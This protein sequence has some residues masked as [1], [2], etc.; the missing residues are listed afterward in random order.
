MHRMVL[1]V[2]TGACLLL[3]FM[4]MLL[5]P[6]SSKD[7]L[8]AVTLGSPF[9]SPNISLNSGLVGYWTMDGKN[10][11]GVGALTSATGGSITTS[12]SDKIHTFTTSG[13][14]TPNG[15]GTVQYLVVAGGGGGGPQAAV[16]AGGGGAG[17]VLTGTT[18]VTAQA[19][20]ITV[21]NGGTPG[22]NGQ[23]SSLGSVVTAIGGGYGGSSGSPGNT[24]G[25][26]GGG[27]DYPSA[28]NSGGAG[29]AGQGNRGGNATTYSGLGGG[30]AGGGGAGGAGVDM[31]PQSLNGT[32][33]GV[34]IASSISGASVYYGGGGGGGSYTNG[35]PGNGGL[36]GGGNGSNSASPGADGTANTGGGGGGNGGSGGSGIVIIRFTPSSTSVV[37]NSGNANSISLTQATAAAGKDGQALSFNG[38]AAYATAVDAASLKPTAAISYGGW[39]YVPSAPAS[40]QS[41]LEKGT[42]TSTAGYGLYVTS[43]KKFCL[44][45]K[46]AGGYEQGAGSVVTVG[47]WHH[48]MVTYDSTTPKLYV[49]GNLQTL[50]SGTGCTLTQNTGAITQDTSALYLGARSSP[51]QFFSGRLDD[52]RV[53]N[54]ALKAAEVSLLS[55]AG[56]G[57]TIAK[58]SIAPSTGGSTS[59]TSGLSAYWPLDG[60]DTTSSGAAYSA[61]GGTITTSGTNT[62]HT[63]TTSGTFAITGTLPSL[64]GLAVGGGGGGGSDD[65]QG[66]GYGGGGGG[67]GGGGCSTTLPASGTY[68]ITVGAKG[69]GGTGGGNANATSGGDSTIV[70]GASTYVTGPGGHFGLTRADN[71]LGGAGGIGNLFTGGAGGD[72]FTAPAG[73]GTSGSGTCGAIGTVGGKGGGTAGPVNGVGST[74]GGGGGGSY[75]VGAAGQLNAGSSAGANT[76]GGGGAAG[77]NAGYY[78]SGD[79]GTGIVILAYPTA[80]PILNTA[81]ERTGNANSVTYGTAATVATGKV[82]QALSFNGSTSYASSTDAAAI[83]PTSGISYGGWVY[84][85]ATP[86]ANQ[87]MLEKGT[88]TSTAGYGLYV[89]SEN[90]FCLGIKTAGGYEQGAGSAVTTG[91]WHHV[92]VTYDSSTPT[93]YVDGYAQSLATGTGCTLTQNTG[94]ITQDTSALY[95]GARAGTSQFFNGRLDDVRVYNRALTATEVSH[96]YSAGTG[97]T[98]GVSSTVSTSGSSGQSFGSGLAGYWTMDG[99]DT[100]ITTIVDRTGSGNTATLSNTAA[101]AGKLGQGLSLNGSTSYASMSDA[102]S[103]DPTAAISYGGWVYV[104]ATPAAN[105]SVLEK[106]T[107]TSTAGYGLYVTSE[108]KFCLGIKTAGGYEQGASN[109]V[110]GSK[111]HHVMVT[112][113]STTPTLYVD[114]YA[115]SLATGTGC[116]LTQNTGAITQDT[117]ALY[118]G[119]RSGTSQFFNGRL[120][121]VRVYNRALTATEVNHMYLQG[122]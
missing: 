61:T 115:Q 60:S 64:T 49:D 98:A 78:A 46:T 111:W 20:T 38:T 28:G 116:T 39:V 83:K 69:T 58:P 4:G 52:M 9:S 102:S 90:K 66:S 113:D 103:L 110:T 27:S 106:G 24:G 109:T 31:A 81:R 121:D 100:T 62:L 104:S 55:G 72:G 91:K 8:A 77:Y 65:S 23:N 30:S 107:A 93:L 47:K 44:G 7:A 86:A 120:D 21:G 105:Q 17:G 26:G 6:T 114:G 79:G 18:A 94:A 84:V 36:G 117:S 76:G 95:F 43:E 48:V 13:T 34:G 71:D 37:D 112:Y 35:T 57:L 14:F 59:L 108:K 11:G 45:I 96:L 82:G 99:K 89:T 15:P 33:G 97:S 54:R 80:T 51:S 92:M 2:A 32:D 5:L 56:G 88:A 119:A 12:G 10:Y 1:R 74:G 73:G 19:Y 50:A 53:Y 22:N 122:K 41:I 3:F 70:Q 85:S 42:A 68:T 29:T 40:N 101:V 118:F 63:F 16:Y 67:G 25:S 87:S 75:G